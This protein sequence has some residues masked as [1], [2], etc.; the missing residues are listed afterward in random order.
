[1]KRV[2]CCSLLTLII[3]LTSLCSCKKNDPGTDKNIQGLVT[4]VGTE[5]GGAVTGK[6]GPSG[7]TLITNDGRVEFVFPAGALNMETDIVIQPVISNIPMAIGNA[8]RLMPGNTEFNNPVILKYHYDPDELEGTFPEAIFIAHQNAEG[9]WLAHGNVVTDT[10]SK[11]IS[12]Q[13]YHFSDWGFFSAYHMEVSAEIVEPDE[14]VDLEMMEIPGA[15]LFF[16]LGQQATAPIGS[17]VPTASET[18]FAIDQAQPLPVSRGSINA[19]SGTSTYTAPSAFPPTSS[20]NLVRILGQIH[21]SPN[22]IYQMTQDISLGGS[23]QVNVDGVAYFFNKTCFVISVGTS[24]QLSAINQSPAYGLSLGWDGSGVG[25]FV[26]GGAIGKPEFAFNTTDK[27]YR[28]TYS[29]CG[30]PDFKCLTT[31][32]YVSRANKIRYVIKGTFNGTLSIVNGQ[33]LC[34]SFLIEQYKEVEMSGYFRV[35]WQNY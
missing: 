35:K 23:V 14:L 18:D 25:R 19:A 20:Y 16:S 3:L 22:Q 13:L 34:N 30:P 33:T 26:S 17:P 28:C 15:S 2:C 1:M 10:V 4:E 32:V 7:G 24:Y 31:N 21:I 11:T 5:I 12:A 27:T 9:I 8:Y 6:I 29:I